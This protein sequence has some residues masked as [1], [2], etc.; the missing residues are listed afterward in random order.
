MSQA[1][2][3]R[4]ALRP[5]LLN[6]SSMAAEVPSRAHRIIVTV[7]GE[8]EDHSQP[9]F[10]LALAKAITDGRVDVDVDLGALDSIDTDDVGLLIRA[11]SLLRSAGWHLVLRAPCSGAILAACALLDPFARVERLYGNEAATFPLVGT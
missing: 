9:V 6:A 11:R 10:V 1:Q 2:D 8:L 7:R 5:D 3:A 4:V